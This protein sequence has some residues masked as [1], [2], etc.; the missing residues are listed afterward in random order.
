MLKPELEKDFISSSSANKICTLEKSNFSEVKDL[1]KKFEII[2]S[3]L[4]NKTKKI[5]EK[6]VDI[7]AKK[8]S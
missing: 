1:T 3:K 6:L 5:K 7:E 2:C 8:E 4:C